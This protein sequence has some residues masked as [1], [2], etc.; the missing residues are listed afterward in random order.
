[1]KVRPVANS[2]EY[3]PTAMLDRKW[4]ITKEKSF[5]LTIG[6]EYIVYAVTA[7]KEAFWYYVLD[8]RGL[9]YP[10][11]Y[12]SPLFEVSDGSVPSHWIVN[13]FSDPNS[14]DRI[15]TSILSFKDWAIDSSFYE[16]LIDGE[17]E[18]VT[19]FK[20]ERDFLLGSSS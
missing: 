17:A 10:V 9:P 19:S 1:M 15:G 4:G 16:R 6:K 8:E 13:Y 2:G 18:A 3:L 5:S 12:P 7:V 11:W 14:R 20:N